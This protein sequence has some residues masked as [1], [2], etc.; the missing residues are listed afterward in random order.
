MTCHISSECLEDDTAKTI[1]PPIEIIVDGE[2]SNSGDE[3]MTARLAIGCTAGH[4][5]L[6]PSR[7]K[8]DIVP[9]GGIRSLEA[10]GTI[11]AL[12]EALSQAIY[13]SARDNVPWRQKSSGQYE[14]CEVRLPRRQV[15]SKRRETFIAQPSWLVLPPRY[16]RPQPGFCI[17]GPT[18]GG[19][20]GAE[21]VILHLLGRIRWVRRRKGFR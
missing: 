17:H 10:N 11:A 4:V 15:G 20:S 8:L 13:T 19:Q 3:A 5:S 12:N 21:H 14:A 2:N 9:L 1:Y 18:T 6:P 16:R 7:A